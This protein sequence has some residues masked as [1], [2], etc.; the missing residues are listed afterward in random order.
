MIY[1][2]YFL[3]NGGRTMKINSKF[4]ENQEAINFFVFSL[5]NE[6]YGGAQ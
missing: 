2:F 6:K 4:D 1:F 5:K 3:N